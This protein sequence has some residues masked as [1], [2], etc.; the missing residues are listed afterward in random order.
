MV[1]PWRQGSKN[2]GTAT[3]HISDQIG[4]SE[5]M[6]RYLITLF[7]WATAASGLQLS[8]A[9]RP[10]LVARSAAR[11]STLRCEEISDDQIKAAAETASEDGKMLWPES[12]APVPGNE[13]V[14]SK[15]ERGE[16]DGFDPRVILY[17]TVPAL[18][19]GGQ[20]FFTFSRDALGETALG[21]AM[22]DLYLPPGL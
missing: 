14:L 17:V 5:V 22:M 10:S 4:H 11:V 13:P 15:E 3:C 16:S 2:P 21:P 19:L 7:L 8:P 12:N 18:V 1:I 6:S 9:A 20:L